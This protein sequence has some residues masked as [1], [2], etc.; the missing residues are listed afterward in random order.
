MRVF[1][2]GATGFI[3]SAVVPELLNAGHQILGLARSDAAAASLTA[4]GAQAHRGDLEDLDG[5]RRGAESC[6]AVIHAGFDHDFSRFAANCEADRRAIEAIGDAIG[7]TDKP[8]VAGRLGAGTLAGAAL[9]AGAACVPLSLRLGTR[10][11]LAHLAAVT[12]ALD[13]AAGDARS[14]L[15]DLAWA[16]SDRRS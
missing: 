7:G 12:S 1:I 2:T 6:D 9:M 14:A 5:L 8:L 13:G 15:E 4:A 3:G 16:L 10:P 11:G